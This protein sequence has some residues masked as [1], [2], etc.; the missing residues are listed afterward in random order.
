MTAYQMSHDIVAGETPEE[1]FHAIRD[2][3]WH[4]PTEEEMYETA[5]KLAG[6]KISTPQ[7]YI[8]FMIKTGELKPVPTLTS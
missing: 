1:I 5:T 6:R 4:K 7:E 3:W 8:D 2:A